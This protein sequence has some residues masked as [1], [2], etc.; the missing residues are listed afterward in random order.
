MNDHLSLSTTVTLT[1]RRESGEP[2]RHKARCQSRRFEPRSSTK[3]DGQAAARG[4]VANA[5]RVDVKKYPKF[6]AGQNCASG[7]LDQGNAAGK[8]AGAEASR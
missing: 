3:R 4:Y 8:A 6:V 7:A 5:K 1:P 2:G